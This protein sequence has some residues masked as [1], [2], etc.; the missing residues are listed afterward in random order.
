[1]KV[2]DILEQNITMFEDDTHPEMA[3]EN[4]NY[5]RDA[6]AELGI[7]Y[8]EPRKTIVNALATKQEGKHRGIYFIYGRDINTNE[9]AYFYIGLASKKTA[10]IVKRF[11]PHYAKLMADLPKL[12]RANK[13]DLTNPEPKRKDAT[14]EYPKNW[15]A[16]VSQQFLNGVEIPDYR[17]KLRTDTITLQRGKNAGKVKKM[18][19]YMPGELDW[20]PPKFSRNPDQLPVLIWNLDHLSQAAIDWLETI[21]IAKYKPIFNNDN[22]KSRNDFPV[23]P[24]KENLLAQPAVQKS[25]KKSKEINN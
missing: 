16:G 20:V 21:L 1:M 23:P 12:Y 22:D 7:D 8:V 15:K 10:S 18:D 24:S 14:Y 4:L 5:F 13:K 3:P 9:L 19:L 17:K 11:E 2:N 6:F 25:I